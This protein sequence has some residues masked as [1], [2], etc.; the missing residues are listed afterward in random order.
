MCCHPALARDAQVGLTLRLLG[1]L[2]TP[3]IARAFLTAEPALA[4]R[5]VRAKR[6]IRAARIPFRV[7]PDHLLPER[8]GAVLS[9]LYLIFNEGYASTAA[10]TLVR[11]D[12]AA[13]AIRLARVLVG[14]MP[15][16]PEARG[17]LA[18]M[19]LQ[20]SRREA[21]VD[22][23]GELTLLE[24]QDRARWNRA[25]IEEGLRLVGGAIRSSPGPYALQAAIAAVHAEAGSAEATDWRQIAALYG[26]L[27]AVSPTPVVELNRAAA[28]AM[29]YG[30]EVGLELVDRIGALERYH[31]FHSARADLLRRLGR[32]EEAAAAYRRALELATNAVE[33]RF[34][35]R[36]LAEMADSPRA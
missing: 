31:L 22:A 12:L 5:L 32:A 35:R 24:D 21:R 30:P 2:T 26:E 1:G 25:E 4:Q 34:L 13:E 17:L 36:R 20:H 3:E 23:A 7:P 19:L 16:E 8:L 27:A 29:A 28:V 6:K 10:D 18:L 9:V 33:R 15:D 14:L 11:R